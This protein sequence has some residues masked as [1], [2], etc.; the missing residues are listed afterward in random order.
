VLDFIIRPAAEDL[1]LQAI[2]A[3]ELA[4]PGQITLQIIEHVLRAR[5]L[6]A[7]LT[8]SNPNVFYELAV[9]NAA[10][11]PVALIAQEGEPLPFDTAQMRTI[12]FDDH[13]LASATACRRQ[14]VA[15]LQRAFDGAVDSP[16]ATAINLQALE[17]G[18]RTEQALADLVTRVDE[19]SQRMTTARPNTTSRFVDVLTALMSSYS[20]MRVVKA[21][22]TLL[23]LARSRDD[24]DLENAVADLHAALTPLQAMID[25]R[26]A[27][28][29]TT[30]DA[31]QGRSALVD[32]LMS[33]PTQ[34]PS[35]ARGPIAAQE[36]D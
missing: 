28:P 2:R 7:D 30:S 22:Q 33:A 34:P 27:Q 13:D 14:I 4:E 18:N 10:R 16:I 36:S 11:L 35:A 21:E 17:G 3:D 5:A 19:L 1:G 23:E 32:A 20:I 6:V 29:P 9:R 12:F 15:H 31:G 24:S 26:L 8:G 25:Q